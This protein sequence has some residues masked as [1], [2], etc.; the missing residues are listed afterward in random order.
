MAIGAHQTWFH[1]LPGAKNIE[2]AVAHALGNQ[3]LSGEPVHAVPHLFMSVFVF[4]LI[5][6]LAVRFKSRVSASP[7]GGVVPERGFNARS[8]VETINGAALSL[9]K[10]VMGEEAARD[11]LPLIGSL[12]FF[13]FFAN[14][15][16]LVPGFLP[17]TDALSTTAALATV[18]FLATHWYGIKKNGME[19]IKHMM[20]PVI[21]LAP[22]M[23]VIEVIS[24]LARPLSLSLR[25]MGN[26]MGDHMVLVLFLGLIPFLVPIPILVLGIIVCTVQTLVFC[27][28][29][30]VYIGMAI[31]DL[32]AHH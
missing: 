10:P 13:I 3:V 9:M 16:G 30:V 20:G 7:D 22:L 26:M 29:S 15:L 6:I 4:F 32:H 31:E 2:H 1:L 8:F 25:L 5:I 11:F 21:W 24:H 18:V 19:H 12:A 17:A 23:F 28:L 14:I 27:L